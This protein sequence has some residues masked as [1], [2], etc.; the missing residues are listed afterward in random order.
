MIWEASKEDYVLIEKIASMAYGRLIK[1]YKDK[2]KPV[3]FDKSDIQLD[4]LAVHLND[5]PIDLKTLVESSPSILVSD[6]LGIMQNIDRET[7]CL[8][9]SFVPKSSLIYSLV[10]SR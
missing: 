1:L 10:G 2:G 4:I 6:V 5:S 8:K 9:T 3:D 7:G